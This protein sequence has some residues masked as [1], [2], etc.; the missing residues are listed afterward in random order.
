MPGVKTWTGLNLE[1]STTALVHL[2]VYNNVEF[3]LNTIENIFFFH[4]LTA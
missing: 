4:L 3:F 2:N 1:L